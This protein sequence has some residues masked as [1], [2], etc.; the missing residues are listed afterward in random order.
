MKNTSIPLSVAFIDKN[1][2]IIN[3]RQMKPYDETPHCS[4]SASKYALEMRSGWFKKNKI[5]LGQKIFGIQK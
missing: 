4:S 1:F 2:K 3:I 5:T